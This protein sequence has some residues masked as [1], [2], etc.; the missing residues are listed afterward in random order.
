VGRRRGPARG[1]GATRMSA[2][3]IPL[4]LDVDTGIDDA[5]AL[6]LAVHS[7]EIDLLAVT[8]VAGNSDIHRTTDNTLRVMSWLR[9]ETV[10]VYRGASHPLVRPHQDAAHVHGTN[11]LGN[12]AFPD[13]RRGIGPLRGPAAIVRLATERPGEITLVCVGPLTNLA[14]ALNVEPALPLLLRR[15]VI[16]GGAYDRPGNIT[17]FAEFNI[18]VDPEAAEQVMRAA[19]SDI[20]LVGLDA[21]HQ[22]PLDRD[23]WE[24]AGRSGARAGVVLARVYADSFRAG[25]TEHTCLHDPLALALAFEPAL[26]E[27]RHGTVSIDLGEK[28]RGRTTVTPEAHGAQ[29]AT[30]VAG[31]RFQA[32]LAERLL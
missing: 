27:Y 11:G 5:V 25:R 17:E 18:Y 23:V 14:I 29:I 21:S 24:R 7:P 4:I 2:G 15:L 20:V 6:A 12:A 22:V 1:G 13:P 16:M 8:T 3:R 9:A 31:P 19:F 28:R 10:P 32:L 26:A 30:A